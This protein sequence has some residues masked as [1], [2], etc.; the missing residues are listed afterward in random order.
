MFCRFFVLVFLPNN[1]LTFST[2]DRQQ[3]SITLDS[4][5]ISELLTLPGIKDSPLVR[6]LFTY[7]WYFCFSRFVPTWYFFCSD[8]QPDFQE[9]PTSPPPS[10]VMPRLNLS[11]EITKI[12]TQREFTSSQVAVIWVHNW[13]CEKKV[14]INNKALYPNLGLI[15]LNAALLLT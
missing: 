2:T 3:R 12:D 9:S 10:C 7:L 13:S 8:I 11:V 15:T 5:S 4:L 6:L 1:K 14:F